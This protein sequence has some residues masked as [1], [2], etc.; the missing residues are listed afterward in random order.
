M[1][2]ASWRA[3]M[4]PSTIRCSQKETSRTEKSRTETRFAERLQT[5]SVSALSDLIHTKCFEDVRDRYLPCLETLAFRLEQL[6]EVGV[7]C[8]RLWTS[9]PSFSKR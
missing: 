4:H 9:S 6:I 2:V 1:L 3:R 8:V 5:A 7:W